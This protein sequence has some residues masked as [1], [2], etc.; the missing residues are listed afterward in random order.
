MNNRHA[1][2]LMKILYHHRIRS[3]DGQYVHL[4]E[5]TQA[6]RALGHE[7]ILVGPAAIEREEFGAEAG[8][9]A[10]LKRCLPRR[11]YETLELSYSLWAYARLRR[12]IRRHKPDCIYERY[13]LFQVA[14]AWG[15]RMYGLPMLLEVN[16]PLLEERQ[17]YGGLS[18][19]GLA[20]WSQNYV[21]QTADYLLPVTEVLAGYLRRAGVPDSRIVVIP[22]GANLARFERTGDRKVAKRRLGLEGRLVL[23]FTGFLREWH[24]LERVI[25]MIAREGDPTGFH[26]LLVGDGPARKSLE[27]LA[28]RL[29]VEG[30]MTITGIV[31]RDEVASYV[32]AF[33]VALQPAVVPYASPLKLF[34][35]MVLGCAI[36][37]PDMPNL[38][39]ILVDTQTALLFDPASPDS[40]FRVVSRVCA[41]AGLRERIGEGAA[42]TIR[43]RGLTWEK[44]AERVV[45]L[46]QSCGVG[47]GT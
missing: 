13:N 28:Q 32:V 16:A 2:C 17:E 21:W 8:I 43:E 40:F 3:K 37:A 4:D 9:V 47:K 20:R 38:R 7:I 31:P 45:S 44:N 23:G 30:S 14:G 26:F 41:D 35:Y 12:A 34:E 22:N 15:R 1:A 10:Y 42:R 46:F 29:G 33:D 5:L 19:I 11:L 36:V 25:E 6:L 24:G 18:S 27:G 39:E